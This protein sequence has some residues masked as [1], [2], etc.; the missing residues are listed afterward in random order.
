MSPTAPLFELPSPFITEPGR[1]LLLEP[2]TADADA[3]SAQLVD[4]RYNRPF[5]ID[6]GELRTLYFSL[7]LIQSTMRL[8]TPNT[9]ELNYTQQM[10]L[11]MPFIP[12][13]RR[14]V[15][16]GLGGGSI[17]KFC[18]QHL[19]GSHLTAVEFN[20][21]VIALRN[22]FALPPDD[23]MLSIVHA[24]GAEYLAQAEAG[25]NVLLVD[26]FNAH[27][28]APALGDITFFENAAAKLSG[29]GVLVVNLAGD[30]HMYSELIGNALTVF[31]DRVILLPVHDDGNHLLFAFNDPAFRPD[32]RRLRKRAQQLRD[33]CPL[34]LPSFIDYLERAGKRR[35]AQRGRRND[36]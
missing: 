34:D 24:D 19:P 18:R 8:R 33:R 15:L 12:R 29:C 4:E 16:I 28:Y 5:V 14:L 13:P 21:D 9:L 32:W 3:L 27:G 2:P 20:P 25:I 7:R 17:V 35:L 31:D 6:D 30:K 26:A 23:D 36:D 1:V 10:M 11:F 22:A